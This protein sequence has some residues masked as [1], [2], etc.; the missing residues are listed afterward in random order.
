[1][2][3]IS[4]ETGG[5]RVPA[6]WS[7]LTAKAGESDNT[8]SL[9]FSPRTVTSDSSGR[10]A[11]RRLAENLNAPIIENEYSLDCVDVT[12]SV[13]HRQLFGGVARELDAVQRARLL[14]QIY[15]PYRERV[16][17][18]I[19]SGLRQSPILIH[20][21]V[22]TFAASSKGHMRRTDVGLLYDPSQQDEV[23]FCLDWIDDLYE[24]APM[25]RVRRNYPRRGTQDSLTRAMR[26]EF[27]N[28]PYVGIE[29]ALNRA[30][31]SRPLKI[32]DEAIDGLSDSLLEIFRLPT[33]EAA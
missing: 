30:W 20:L 2:Y 6:H 28:Q 14:D 22:R 24:I 25:L 7:S 10:Y 4:C 17:S 29:L 3:L 13:R 23:D 9:V 18:A 12:R 21:S 11:A 8:H 19:K 26:A 27:F 1:M 32:R 16:R 15:F 5:R 31:A 33:A